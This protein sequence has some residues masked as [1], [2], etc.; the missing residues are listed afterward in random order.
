MTFKVVRQN[1]MRNCILFLLSHYGKIL[2]KRRNMYTPDRDAN[3]PDTDDNFKTCIECKG[4]GHN[5]SKNQ[6]CYA[7]NGDGYLEKED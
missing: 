6:R 1:D 5:H 2:L 7:C 3:P 4:E